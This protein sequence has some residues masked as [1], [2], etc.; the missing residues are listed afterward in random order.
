MKLDEASIRAHYPDWRR[1]YGWI[2]PW[3]LYVIGYIVDNKTVY[4][5]LLVLK[6]LR[7]LRL[8]EAHQLIRTHLY[9]ISGKSQMFTLIVTLLTAIHFFA[10]FGWLIGWREHVAGVQS[11]WLDEFGLIDKSNAAQYF[12]MFYFMLSTVTTIGYGDIHAVTFAEMIFVIGCEVVGVFIYH[13]IVST[14]VAIITDPSRQR[15]LARFRR[16]Y[17]TFKWRNIPDSVLIYLLRYY[18]FVWNRDRNRE[19][20]YENARKL[21][22]EGLQKKIRLAI[23]LPLFSHLKTFCDIS[24]MDALE[25]FA[26]AMK[27]RV[28]TPGDVLLQ[29][30]KISNSLFFVTCGRL[31]YHTENNEF[32]T[33]LDA[34]NSCLVGENS[35]I[36][37]K[38]E[39][40]SLIAQSYVEALE[41]TKEAFNAIVDSHPDLKNRKRMLESYQIAS[42]A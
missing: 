28:F 31:G 6:L 21:M 41:I 7:V 32:V 30:G 13:Y 12:Y 22:P 38:K 40:Y 2:Y 39:G 18:E 14:F 3:P 23:H 8:W 36:Y 25:K 20:F 42:E 19:F 17:R 15:F 33:G 34:T 1:L 26:L 29:R 27:P 4:R 37:G 16:V 5:A 11:S 10:C 9:Y 35:M 24:D